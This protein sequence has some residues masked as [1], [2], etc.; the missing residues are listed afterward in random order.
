MNTFILS[1]KT[2]V[3]KGY[4]NGQEQS[5]GDLC[6]HFEQNLLAFKTFMIS[7]F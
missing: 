4:E 1:F 7:I 3:N 2:S 6:F 5:N